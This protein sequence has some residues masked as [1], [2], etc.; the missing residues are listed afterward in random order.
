MKRFLIKLA[1][2]IGLHLFVFAGTL[3]VYFKRFPPTES[4]YASSLDKHQLLKTRPSPR[5]I[6]IGGSSMALGMD[7][8]Q[9]ARPFGFHPINM[10]L[11]M[12]IGLEF[13]LDE[14]TASLRPGD[15]VIVAPEYHTF[16]N[17]YRAEPEYVARLIEC[18]P[19][20]LLDL[21]FRTTKELLDH[22]YHQHIGR[23]IRTVL[24]VGSTSGM[25]DNLVNAYNHRQAFNE[26]GDVIAHHGVQTA[27]GNTLRFVITSPETMEIA[28]DH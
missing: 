18:R 24:G 25:W 9:V 4:Y 13:M 16:Q 3:A 1:F 23:V 5:M 26:N 20:L 8:A 17:S 15:L 6:F 27:R 21:P 19:S 11:N 14:V 10:G 7:S 22:G 12:G 28:I 2:F